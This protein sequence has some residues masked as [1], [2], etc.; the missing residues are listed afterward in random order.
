MRDVFVDA[1]IGIV[2][3]SVGI[4]IRLS[5]LCDGDGSDYVRLSDLR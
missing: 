2:V 4:D 1:P 3:S 5:C